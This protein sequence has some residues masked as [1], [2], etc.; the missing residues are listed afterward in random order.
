MKDFIDRITYNRPIWVSLIIV[1]GFVFLNSFFSAQQR[2]AKRAEASA[3]PV[4]S[5]LATPIPT[6]VPTPYTSADDKFQIV[7]PNKPTFKAGSTTIMLVIKIPSMSYRAEIPEG[8]NAGMYTVNVM[9]L[10]DEEVKDGSMEKRLNGG[11]DAVVDDDTKLVSKRGVTFKGQPAIEARFVY[12]KDMYYI[13]TY[14]F[15]NGNKSYNLTTFSPSSADDFGKEF[16]DSFQL[17]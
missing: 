7:F 14:A 13:L 16:F 3:T 17:L 2:A 5:T 4:A 12:K 1:F 11:I 9:T 15:E 10:P 8:A 6:A